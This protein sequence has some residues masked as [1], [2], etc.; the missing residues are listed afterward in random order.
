MSR[1]HVLLDGVVVLLVI[2]LTIVYLAVPERV[3]A[4]AS[5]F[6]WY[7]GFVQLVLE[8]LGG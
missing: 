2:G 4:L 3:L 7:R 6:E 5:V 1:D 8:M